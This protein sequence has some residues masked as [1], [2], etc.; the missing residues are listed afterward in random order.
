MRQLILLSQYIVNIKEAKK[1]AMI[2]MYVGRSLTLHTSFNLCS[3]IIKQQRTLT[4]F[5]NYFTLLTL[6]TVWQYE[7]KQNWF[8]YKRNWDWFLK[9]ISGHLNLLLNTRLMWT[10]SWDTDR[11]IWKTLTER[12]QAN[13]FCNMHKGWVKW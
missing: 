4:S 10:Q 11:S 1:Q 8:H 3:L 9:S 2:Y 7:R 12:K 5:H 6:C 13:D